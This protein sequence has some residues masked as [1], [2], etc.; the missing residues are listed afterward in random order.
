MEDGR[1]EFL[2]LGPLEVRERGEPMSVG[3]ARQRALLA[4]LL[5]SANRVVSRDRLIEELNPDPTSDTADH[6][7]HVQVSRLRKALGTASRDP[8]VVARPPGYLLRVEPDELD[9]TLFERRVALGRKLLLEGDPVSAAETLASALAL[10]R[11][12]ALAGLEF[13]S[14]AR[15]D[16]ERLEELRLNAL[17]DRVDADI[18]CGRHADV[19]PELESVIAAH[20]LRERPRAQLMLA[21]YRSGRQADALHAYRVARQLLHDDHGLE[22][23]IELQQL[24]RAILEQ[25]P[26]LEPAS[27]PAVAR[28]TLDVCPFKGLAPYAVDDAELFFGRERLV[29]ELVG[30]VAI[31]N[32]VTIVGSSGSGKSSLLRAGLLAALAGGALEGSDAWAQVVFRP[33]ELPA[34]A[35]EEALAVAASNHGGS[36]ARLVVA[37]DQVEELFTSCR[38]EDERRRFVDCLLDLAWN[39]DRPALIV[40]ALRADFYG[41]LALEPELAALAG[42]RATLVGPMSRSELRRVISGP[43]ELVGLEID[44]PL[45]DELVDDTVD[46]PGGLPLLSTALLELWTEREG[47]L[48]RL[49]DYE[50]MG[51]VRGA[52]ARMAESAY[53]R[54]EPLERDA[55]RRLFLRLAATSD[56]GTVVRRRVP[57]TDLQTVDLSAAASALSARRLVTIDDQT[58]EVAHEALLREWPR[59]R[60]WLAEDADGRRLHG[61]LGR[62]ASEWDEGGRDP[63]LLYRGRRLEAAREWADDP[64]NAHRL[65]LVEADFLDAGAAAATRERDRQRRANRRLLTAL[66]AVLVLLVLA[67]VVGVVAVIQRGEARR[68][69]TIADSERLGAQALIEPNLDRS[70]LLARA[71]YALDDSEETG[72]A[73]LA[74]VSRSPR[75]IAVVRLSDRPL[76]DDALSPDGRTLAVLTDNGHVVF[77]DTATWRPVGAPI[78]TG[79]QLRYQYGSLTTPIRSLAFSPDGRTLAVGSSDGTDAVFGLVDV[80]THRLRLE[81]AS[82]AL[83]ADVAY[84]SDGRS[85]VTGERE[86]CCGPRKEIVVSRTPAGRVVR[87][88]PPI[89][90]GRLV[91]FVDHDRSLLVT[92]GEAKAVVLDARTLKVERRLGVREP[93]AISPDE[94]QVAFGSPSGTIT[95]LDVSDQR[96]RPV[97]RI[98]G[99]VNGLSYEAGGSRLAVTSSDGTVATWDVESGSVLQSLGGRSAQSV[100]PVSDSRRRMLIAAGDDGS[101]IAW[102]LTGRAGLERFVNGAGAVPSG[103]SRNGLFATSSQSGRVE[104]WDARRLRLRGRLAGP[105]GDASSI[106]ISADGRVLA[107]AGSRSVSV[108]STA[109]GK[110]VRT[111]PRTDV[112]VLALDSSGRRLAVGGSDTAKGVVVYDVG[113]GS[114]AR[115]YST[116][117]GPSWTALSFSPDGRLLAV[118][119]LAGGVKVYRFDDDDVETA[120]SPG[121]N[122]AV[123]TVALSPDDALLATGDSNDAVDFW[124]VA[125]G[126]PVGKPLTGHNGLVFGLAFNPTGTEV[127]SSGIDGK[128]RLWDVASRKLIGAP[129]PGGGGTVSFFDDGA[130]LYGVSSEDV[131]TTWDVDPTDWAAAACRIANRRLTRSEWSDAL[132]GRAYRSIC[133]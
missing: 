91:G 35:L 86:P 51:R 101:E 37:V 76:I 47:S 23:G 119:D 102:D 4:L 71:A 26:A 87:T 108:W 54:L 5:L 57:L 127:A 83:V 115:V 68:Q 55:A 25:D 63:A 48:I 46:E 66:A 13:E 121:H 21:L 17:E 82:G 94:R 64:H 42:D 9:L 8:R 52:V 128:L 11:G 97:G 60:D 30:I 16:V 114:I 75:A 105:F 106:A 81:P 99:S 116:I 104:L 96:A 22:P 31:Q 3:G 125:T 107:A 40:L 20:P 41:H 120:V 80:R 133:G 59:L 38:S 103:T 77:V 78:E 88:S 53:S 10:W 89:V 93:A 29:E 124:D 6:A 85:L 28:V 34:S 24:E 79:D 19:V 45:V 90:N 62:A 132:P 65:N 73:L 56:D 1:L 69:A 14:F 92:A 58:V 98:S 111:L 95:A 32:V 110:L 72:S 100:A 129:L 39:A 61:R 49:S 112:T 50:R 122:I 43:L 36:T 123:F 7:L 126:K 70:L 113:N 84:S 130:R 67:G 15:V 12:P 131:E 118:A 117:A 33:G 74:A 44:A 2:I 109:T 18:A 27:R